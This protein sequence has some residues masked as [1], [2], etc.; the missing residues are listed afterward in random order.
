MYRKVEFPRAPSLR[1]CGQRS[2]WLACLYRR[3]RPPSEYKTMS[4][5]LQCLKAIIII[6]IHDKVQARQI[7]LSR[8]CNLFVRLIVAFILIPIIN[9]LRDSS[10]NK[11]QTFKKELLF[12]SFALFSCREMFRGA[13][14]FSLLVYCSVKVSV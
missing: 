4:K 7:R 10:W 9:M 2:L 3:K 8:E 1:L 14:S 6:I 5:F 11:R 12:S 13:I